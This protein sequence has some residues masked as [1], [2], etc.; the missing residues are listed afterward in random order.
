MGTMQPQ[1]AIKP[2]IGLPDLAGD[3][4][5]ECIQFAVVWVLFD[6]FLHKACLILKN[7][8]KNINGNANAIV[9]FGMVECH[10]TPISASS[11]ALSI[12][13][14]KK[15]SPTYRKS[16]FAIRGGID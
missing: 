3:R 16:D 7:V 5:R 8:Q 2:L 6:I 14:L 10:K 11:G 12:T 9:V 13:G 4:D 1:I 15:K